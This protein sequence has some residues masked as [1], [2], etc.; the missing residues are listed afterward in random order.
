MKTKLAHWVFMALFAVSSLSLYGCDG[1]AEE[2]GE[3]IDDAVE[4]M[5][6]KIEDAT[7]KK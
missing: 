7:D 6:D 5:G 2:A 4:Q 1:G 3:D